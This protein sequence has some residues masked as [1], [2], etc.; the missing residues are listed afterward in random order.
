MW[1]DYDGCAHWPITAPR[2]HA[3]GKGYAR[4]PLIDGS[5]HVLCL[6]SRVDSHFNVPDRYE[7][8]PVRVCML[9][10]RKTDYMGRWN[11]K[12]EQIAGKIDRF[13]GNPFT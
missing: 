8:A 13:D 11:N 6:S 9:E 5:L 3:P 4:L 2:H 10:M 7:Y 12:F 1:S